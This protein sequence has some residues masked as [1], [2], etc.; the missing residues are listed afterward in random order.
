[1]RVQDAGGFGLLMIILNSM[2]VTSL[3]YL[4]V[5][6]LDDR[7]RVISLLYLGTR[8]L[9]GVFLGFGGILLYFAAVV[10]DGTLA[11]AVSTINNAA[12]QTGMFSLGIGSIL[13]FW[14]MHAGKQLPSWLGI[15]GIVGYALLGASAVLDLSGSTLSTYAIVPGGLFEVVFA[16]WMIFRGIKEG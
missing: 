7:S 14:S 10:P 9:E 1:V 2:V 16:I 6:L 5:V 3:G 12:Y 8:I 13:L 4:F 15:W 11:S